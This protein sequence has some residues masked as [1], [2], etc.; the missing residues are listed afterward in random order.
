MIEQERGRKGGEPSHKYIYISNFNY[1]YIYFSG[2]SK[3]Q[4]C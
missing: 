1:I 3:A 2:I 4:I